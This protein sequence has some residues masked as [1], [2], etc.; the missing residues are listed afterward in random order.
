MPNVTLFGIQT[1]APAVP[2]TYDLIASTDTDSES[3]NEVRILCDTTL[4]PI[5]LNLPP[6]SS[7]NGIWNLKLWIIDFGGNASVNNIIVNPDIVAG[8]T[9]TQNGGALITEPLAYNGAVVPFEIC[10]NNRW[11]IAYA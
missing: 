6:I 7:F 8:D 1:L 4:A 2:T 5:T 11:W 3:N 9:I 10:Y